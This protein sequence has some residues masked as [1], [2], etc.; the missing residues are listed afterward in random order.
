MNKSFSYFIGGCAIGGILVFGGLR[1]VDWQ[2]SESDN[3][4][5]VKADDK[6]P[7]KN[8][9]S[10]KGEQ[11]NTTIGDSPIMG[12][13]KKAQVAIVEYSDFE[14]PFCKRFHDQTLGQIKKDYIDS[15]KAIFVYRN[16]ALSFHEPAATSDAI[17]ALCAQKIGND[18]KYYQMSDLLY[19]NS[20]LNGKGL[21]N[22]KISE[23]AS[24]IG[25]N[26]KK[27]EECLQNSKFADQ[28][29]KD[30]KE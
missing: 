12:D 29:D 24:Q 25:L 1:L 15:N 13:K 11:K 23:L 19:S 26:K 6:L 5:Q 21:A 14:C 22:D 4:K 30:K 16:Y 18:D 17:A 20:G 9:P 10:V 8:A 28:L 7:D 27:Y 3:A 2:K